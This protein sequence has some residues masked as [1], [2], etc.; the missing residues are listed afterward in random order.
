M[1]ARRSGTLGTMDLP[2]QVRI[3]PDVPHAFARVVA[4]TAP[5]SI[6]LSG[7]ELAH[8]CYRAL[9]SESVDWLMIDVF[10]GDDRNVPVDHEDSNEG[11]ARAM[12]LDHVEPRAVHSMRALGA[13]AYDALLRRRPAIDIVHLGLGPDGHTASLFPGSPALQERDRLVVETGDELHP[14]PR[15]TFTFP[16]IER[17]ALAVVTVAGEEK[18]EAVKRI[19]A[20]D[21]LPGAHIRAGQVLWLGDAA[22]LGN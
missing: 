16:A 1:N 5:R 4:E 8:R 22:A 7:G 6:A 20:G 14:H 17:C 12:L 15:I 21:D 2:G 9:R 19:R 11:A 3:V 18:R 13:D 10:F